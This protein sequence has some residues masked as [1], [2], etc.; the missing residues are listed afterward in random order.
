MQK[1]FDNK[2]VLITGAGSGIGRA[3]ALAFAREGARIAVADITEAGGKETVAQIEAAGGTARFF[4]LDVTKS[5]EVESLV[6]QI[7]E[8]W[9]RLDITLN[10]A[11]VDN[12]MAPI[13]ETSEADFD[14][15]IA[16]NLKGV[17]L[18]MKY[19]IA[20]MEKQGGGV[21]INTASA[22]SITVVPGASPYNA[23][24]H[25]VAGLT[26]TVAVEVGGKNIRV[27]AI[28][29]GVIRTPLL[30]NHPNLPELEKSLL[31]LHPI[32]RLGQ[33]DEVANAVLWLASDKASFVHGALLTV[34]GG[35]TAM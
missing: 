4:R 7:V 23:S 9:G 27:N 21:V 30:E 29:P 17:W 14:R 35:W 12:D 8:T 15:V 20:Q 6:R 1:E 10:N 28:C 22:L 34:D 11:G 25:A 32:G 26:K 5:S 33:V 24:K 31:P 19:A 18:C 16:V 13:T 2:V 3:A